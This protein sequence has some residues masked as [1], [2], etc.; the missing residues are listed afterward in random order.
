MNN[1]WLS[2]YAL[3]IYLSIYL[4]N[5]THILIYIYIYI[6][7][8]THTHTHTHIYIYIYIYIFDNYYTVGSSTM[9]KY[10][11]W[12]CRIHRQ[13]ICRGVRPSKRVSWIGHKT[14]WSWGFS[15]AWAL[16][17]CGVPFHCHRSYVH[18]GPE[19]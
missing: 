2:K 16:V 14:I 19:W 10:V 9:S 6:Y 18:S 15:D 3:S 5:Y 17:K 1:N 13:H 8:H 11:G 7:I 4:E 12:G